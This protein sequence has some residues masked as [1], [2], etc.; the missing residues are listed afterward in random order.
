M[1]KIYFEKRCIMVCGMD[2]PVLSDPNVI[3][4]YPGS[5]PDLGKLAAMMESGDSLSRICIP[6]D[7]E[8]EAYGALCR[9]FREVN[10]G[11]GL[12]R[13]RRGDYLLIYRNGLWDLPKGHQE[14]GEDIETTS[15]R[16]VQEETGLDELEMGK[17][18]CVTDHCYFR[19]GI[20]HLK[21]SWWYEMFYNKP[22]EL[23][24]QTE[25]DI[26]KAVWVPKSAL[27]AY[28]TNTFPSIQE[29]FREERV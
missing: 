22:V 14:E 18:I 23:V 24:P 19:N 6:S 25:E 13:N 3:C 17:L 4:F 12:V 16:E 5:R 8:D 29:V 21:H 1:R 20:W 9:E 15:V 26:S 28:L 11:G 7:D 10:A 27:A 2:S